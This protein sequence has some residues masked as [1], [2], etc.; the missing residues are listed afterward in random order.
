[1]ARVYKPFDI[2]LKVRPPEVL[3]QVAA[4]R[5]SPVVADIISERQQAGGMTTL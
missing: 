2:Q 1:M 3:N 4:H 5:I